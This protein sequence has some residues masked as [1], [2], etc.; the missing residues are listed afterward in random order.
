MGM[1][2]APTWFRQVSPP[3]SRITAKDHFNHCFLRWADWQTNALQYYAAAAFINAAVGNE[4]PA[5]LCN[6]GISGYELA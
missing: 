4:I 3:A 5:C 2:F 1:E 6:P